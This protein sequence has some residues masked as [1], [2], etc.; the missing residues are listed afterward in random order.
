MY[1]YMLSLSFFSLLF[2]FLI[3]LPF[4]S[5]SPL[6]PPPARGNAE[7]HH[8]GHGLDDHV[9]RPKLVEALAGLKVVDVAAG[10]HHCLALTAT[11]DVYGWGRNGSG[12]VEPSGDVVPTPALILGASK[13]GVVSL[14]CGMQEVGVVVGGGGGA[15]GVC[16]LLSCTSHLL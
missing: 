2:S 12:E 16:Y 1:M 11:G 3:F 13:R 9:R 6:P 8:L 7:Y 5:P 10:P 14:S 15:R 4:P